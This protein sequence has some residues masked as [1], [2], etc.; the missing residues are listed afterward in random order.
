MIRTRLFVPGGMPSQDT[1]GDPP[2][3]LQVYA[4][5]S[6]EPGAREAAFSVR[7]SDAGEMV[8]LARDDET[9]VEGVETGGLPVDTHPERRIHATTRIIAR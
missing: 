8:S 7:L 9:P 4:S 2:A 3:P 5:G 6:A 1:G